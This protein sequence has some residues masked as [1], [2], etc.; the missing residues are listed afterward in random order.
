MWVQSV[1]PQRC[2][3]PYY[4]ISSAN[5]CVIQ[6]NCLLPYI[7]PS[8]YFSKLVAVIVGELFALVLQVQ[9]DTPDI[10]TNVMGGI[11]VSSNAVIHS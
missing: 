9:S 6:H 7:N 11:P 3:R 1:R 5:T 4:I 2:N 8:Y 10:S